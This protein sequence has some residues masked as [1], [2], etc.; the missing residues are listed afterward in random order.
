MAGRL[1]T[2]VDVLDRELGGG[3]P[4]GSVVSFTAPPA[5]QAELLLFELTVPRQTLYL[6]TDR[7]EEAVKDA[8]DATHA[9]TGAPAIRY[10]AGDDPLDNAR[11]AFRAA[12][13]GATVIID[14]NDALERTDRSRYESF[15]NELSN[16]MH[17]T[18]GVAFLHCLSGEYTPALRDTTKHM[19]D[20]ILDLALEVTSSS[21]ETRLTVPKLRGGRALLEPI[22][23]DLQERVRVDT[24]RDIA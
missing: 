3:I 14:P 9:P 19:A 18:G 13:E 20:V 16:H 24:S 21:V 12:P 15:L 22:K 2:G 7:T 5:S 8:F 23:L 1:S 10:A 4:A 17:N 6:T 11:R